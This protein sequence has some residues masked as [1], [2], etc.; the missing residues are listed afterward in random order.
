MGAGGALGRLGGGAAA[1][2]GVLGRAHEGSGGGL[3]CWETRSLGSA[4][5]VGQGLRSR[6]LPLRTE[7]SGGGL[8]CWEARSLGSLGT[9]L[10]CR[11]S[12]AGQGL[13]WASGVAVLGELSAFTSPRRWEPASVDTALQTAKIACPQAMA[14][15]PPAQ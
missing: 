9:E 4:G 13:S 12:C 1:I 14:S 5:A 3:S 15:F 2:A 6:R 8:S 11:R 10:G 7:E